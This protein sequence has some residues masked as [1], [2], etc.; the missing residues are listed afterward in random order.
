MP[1][2][3]WPTRHILSGQ[4]S[5]RSIRQRGPPY[6]NL[7]AHLRH[8]SCLA[9]GR[10][11]IGQHCRHSK[12]L[13]S[14]RR[15]PDSRTA[16]D[17]WSR[18]TYGMTSYFIRGTQK[19]P[20]QPRDELHIKTPLMCPDALPIDN[21]EHMVRQ[22]GKRIAHLINMAARVLRLARLVCEKAASLWMGRSACTQQSASC[23]NLELAGAIGDN[24]RGVKQRSAPISR[25]TGSW[26]SACHDQVS[27]GTR[28][29]TG[30][31]FARSATQLAATGARR[32]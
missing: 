5:R 27:N 14:A 20:T 4:G 8:R 31:Q 26:S 9:M 6:L 11:L 22:R 10:K 28:S 2:L 15:A 12:I 23:G 18:A 1:G 16:I 13:R 19:S 7:S 3:R 21:A 29:R 25:N 30:N 32:N 24:D 17:I